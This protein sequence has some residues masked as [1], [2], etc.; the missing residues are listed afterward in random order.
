MG[1]VTESTA[2]E[3]PAAPGEKTFLDRVLDGIERG[4]NKMP[5]PAILFLALCSI[6]IVLSQALAWLDV[7]ATYEV[8]KPPAVPTEETYYGGSSEPVDVGPTEPV[9]PRT[10]GS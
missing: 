3:A 7:N 4:G 2:P 1:T 6:V 8:V 5:H 10:T 9:A